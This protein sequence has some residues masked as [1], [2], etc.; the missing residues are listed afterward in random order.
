VGS[1]GLK[2][3]VRIAVG[4]TPFSTEVQI[5]YLDCKASPAKT[6]LPSR[7]YFPQPKITRSSRMVREWKVRNGI[8]MLRVGAGLPRQWLAVT[9]QDLVPLADKL[10]QEEIQ[11]RQELAGLAEDLAEEASQRAA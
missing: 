2:K 6:L 10:T 9:P 11:R 5:R 1:S 8:W 4:Q 3:D 7:H